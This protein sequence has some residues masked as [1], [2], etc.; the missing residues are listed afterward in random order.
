MARATGNVPSHRRHKKVLKNAA[1]YY[2]G[3][4]RL[5]RPA[6]EAVNRARK[7]RF[8]DERQ[9]RRMI[10]R[11]W[12]TRI[13]IAVRLQGMS[14]SRFIQGLSKANI[15]LDRKVLAQMAVEDMPALAALV[16]K[17]KEALS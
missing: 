6:R 5:Y 15:G 8:R 16:G 13:G 4:S 1:G 7:Y 2:G 12:I 3:R 9:Q 10:R 14:Y 17:A 11:L